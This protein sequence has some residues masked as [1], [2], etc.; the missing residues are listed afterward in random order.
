MNKLQWIRLKPSRS[1]TKKSTRVWEPADR[2]RNRRTPCALAS[3]LRGTPPPSDLIGGHFLRPRRLTGK[4]FKSSTMT[5]I[6]STLPNTLTYLGNFVQNREG[7]RDTVLRAPTPRPNL[8]G[9]PCYRNH[10][11]PPNQIPVRHRTCPIRV[12]RDQAVPPARHALEYRIPENLCAG[13]ARIQVIDIAIALL[14]VECF[15][16]VAAIRELLRKTA[17]F[18]TRETGTEVRNTGVRATN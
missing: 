8:H 13:I 15:V 7:Q 11:Y 16:I 12:P 18:A 2:H 6:R 10:P 5:R 17:H 1:V 9:G 14:R 4:R 3:P